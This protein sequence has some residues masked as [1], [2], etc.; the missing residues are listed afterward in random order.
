[1]IPSSRFTSP[2]LYLPGQNIL[3]SGLV[4]DAE[5]KESLKTEAQHFTDVMK[6]SILHRGTRK[7]IICAVIG[8][9]VSHNIILYSMGL[10]N[11]NQEE[12]RVRHNQTSINLTL[13]RKVPLR[14][15][16]ASISIHLAVEGYFGKPVVV[17][18]RNN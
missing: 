17:T 13:L 9:E 5:R 12:H 6:N 4:L 15:V 16:L 10:E 11:I 1:M 8:Y 3:L 2:P 18:R 14:D 7:E